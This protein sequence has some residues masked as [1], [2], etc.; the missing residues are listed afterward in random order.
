ML[1][2][3][4]IRDNENSIDILTKETG[5]LDNLFSFLSEN[6]IAGVNAVLTPTTTVQIDTDWIL[7][8]NTILI[9]TAKKEVDSIKIK[10]YDGQS[11]YD[12]C[13][14]SYG[15]LDEL[16][17]FLKENNKAGVDD[18]DLQLKNVTLFTNRTSTK[19][20]NKLFSTLSKKEEVSVGN[21][22]LLE[23]GFYLL[24]ENG[25]KFLLENN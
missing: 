8:D 23:N 20:E 9:K 3:Y 4:N 11:V 13:L 2:D 14:Q 5:N 7:F 22:I 19:Y 25:S 16:M 6:N 10:T 18:A 15:S 1:K 24:Q 17:Q 12:V 21:F